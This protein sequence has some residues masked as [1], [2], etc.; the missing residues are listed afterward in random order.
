MLFRSEVR[1]VLEA[2]ASGKPATGAAEKIETFLKRPEFQ[3]VQDVTRTVEQPS[4]AGVG[5]SGEPSGGAVAG[6]VAQPEPSGMVPAGAPAGDVVG[7]KEQQPI[8]V[9]PEIQAAKDLIGAID[10]GGVPLNPAKINNI[11]RD[12]GL[13]VKK[14]AKP[15]ETIQRIRD[16]V[17]RASS[18]PVATEVLQIGR[19]HV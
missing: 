9:A 4:G 7:R 3:G 5:V 18:Q 1:Q 17:D 19:A 8:A 14:S 6:A 2:Y 12:L 16:A 11:A 13:E 15:E 10:A